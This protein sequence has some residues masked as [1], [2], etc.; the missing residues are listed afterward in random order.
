VQSYQI[1]PPFG[2]MG[3]RNWQTGYFAQDDW[4]TTEPRSYGADPNN[5][6]SKLF[7]NLGDVVVENTNGFSIYHSLQSQLE[8]PCRMACS[9]RPATPGR[10][11]STMRSTRWIAARQSGGFPQSATGTRYSSP[12]IRHRFVFSSVAE[13]PF[14]RGRMWATNRDG[15]EIAARAMPPERIEL[16]Q[17]A[18]YS[19]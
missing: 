5:S 17:S 8:H 12:D 6:S 16:Y 7:P 9:S 3:T 1:G 4:C 2:M 14:G 11:Q 10:M 18:T 15:G 19:Y 13:L